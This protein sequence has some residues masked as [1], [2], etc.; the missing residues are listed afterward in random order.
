MTAI[1]AA[2]LNITALPGIPIIRPGDDLAALIRAGLDR[3]GIALA[4]GDVL[5]VASK[6]LS[7]AAGRY[8]DLSTVE[9]SPRAHEVA[10]Q[11]GH[12]PR[13]VEMILRHSRAISR[14]APGVLIVRHQLG[15]VG[16]NAGIDHSNA[17]PPDAPRDSGPWILLLPEDP[18]ADAAKLRS[19]LMTSCG[20]VSSRGSDSSSGANSTAGANSDDDPARVGIGVVISDSMGRPFRFGTVGTA[21]GVAGLPALVDCRGQTDLFDRRLEHTEIAL[22][23]QIACAADM[24]AGQ[25]DE[26]RGVIHLRGL[27]WPAP[28]PETA[29]ARA[30]ERPQERDLYA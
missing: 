18:D 21:I 5:V 6:L 19:A 22:A 14:A 30:L 29:T 17:E 28:S 25:S 8:C 27:R 24:V 2:Q 23:D 3:A 13:L 9:P 1:S 7:R 26:A 20:L 16:A 11:T 10:S 12:D 15:F 4:A